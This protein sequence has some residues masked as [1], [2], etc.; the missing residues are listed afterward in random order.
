MSPLPEEFMHFPMRRHGMDH[1][2]YKWRNLFEEKKTQW[3]G[4]AS[5]ALSILV[6]LEWFPL[7]SDNK[8]FRPPG[9]MLTPY[10]DL[11]HYSSRDYGNRVAIMRLLEVF[12][13]LGLAVTFAVNARLA[14]R[15][16][17]LIEAV[18]EPG[19]HEIAAHGLDMNSLHYGGM[20]GEE[21]LIEQTLNLLKPHTDAP[22]RGWLSP[23]RSQSSET[24]QLLAKANLD[25]CL[26]WINDDMPFYMLDG[27]LV[28]M[29]HSEELC[30]RQIILDYRH[31]EDS[32]VEQIEDAAICLRREAEKYGGR[33][34]SLLLY[35][36]VSGLPYR[37]DYLSRALGSVIRTGEVW[38]ATSAQIL[39]VWRTQHSR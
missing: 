27:K 18:R 26:D 23:A 6:P 31:T 35:P 4:S 5:L 21:E 9:G 28:A 11:R 10:P 12:D 3:P 17:E 2:L 34:L 20:E 29:P 13:R 1:D 39:D 30:D 22:I 25:Y 38:S 8:P 37:I 32:F 15:Y 16:S 36:W 33:I 24:L 19:C 7:N 14:D